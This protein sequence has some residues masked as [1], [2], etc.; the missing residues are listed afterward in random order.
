[1]RTFLLG[2]PSRLLTITDSAEIVAQLCSPSRKYLVA[3]ASSE[4]A[5]L[6]HPRSGCELSVKAAGFLFQKTIPKNWM[7]KLKWLYNSVY[8]WENRLGILHRRHNKGRGAQSAQVGVSSLPSYSPF[9]LIRLS[10]VLYTFLALIRLSILV[11][12]AECSTPTTSVIR[13]IR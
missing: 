11:F 10:S 7:N 2:D 13:R 8:S 1:Q 4:F 6:P 9:T 12:A 5:L 3:L